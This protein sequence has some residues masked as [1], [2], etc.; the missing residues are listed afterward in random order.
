[1]CKTSS[2]HLPPISATRRAACP[3]K[4]NVSKIERQF[5]SVDGLSRV[6]TTDKSNV[7]EYLLVRCDG[8]SIV[9]GVMNG[10]TR[11]S[12][13]GK[14][15]DTLSCRCSLMSLSSDACPPK[16]GCR[17]IDERV[18]IIIIITDLYSAFRS[19]DTEALGRYRDAMQAKRPCAYDLY[20]AAVVWQRLQPPLSL[21]D[22]LVYIIIIRRIATTIS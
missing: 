8:L 16:L 12:R 11:R 14:T 2:I 6:L 13:Q 4:L 15:Y 10:A 1:M 21:S 20:V 5:R 17:L 19:E 18:V 22:A 9:C 7:H 3:E